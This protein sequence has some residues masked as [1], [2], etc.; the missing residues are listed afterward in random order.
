M[1][2]LLIRA[3]AVLVFL[4]VLTVV[5][6]AI[7]PA[8]AQ[9]TEVRTIT[10][11]DATSDCISNPKTPLCAVETFLACGVRQ[12]MSLCRKVGVDDFG[13]DDS[14]GAIEYVVTS[15]HTIR[16]EDIP[17]RLR[18]T[19]WFRPGYEEI[20]ILERLCSKMEVPC[21]QVWPTPYTFNVR[22]I[23]GHW[24]IV[25]WTVGY[26]TEPDDSGTQPGDNKYDDKK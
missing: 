19:E 12:D 11:T 22:P 8:S 10:Q 3:L 26:S 23:D 21:P 15:Q 13:F 2:P 25:D 16:E 7:T 5:L 18:N 17:D 24:H 1:R 20:H 14:I 9:L 6:P 4:S